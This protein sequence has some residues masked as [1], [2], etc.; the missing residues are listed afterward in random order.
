M[1]NN[2]LS[3]P[4]L[5]GPIAGIVPQLQ[6]A[7]HALL[8]VLEDCER[9]AAGLGSA[10]LWTELGG[11][12]SVGFHLRHISGSIDRLLTYA[13]GNS[14]NDAQKAALTAEKAAGDPPPTSADLLLSL[15]RTIER[16]LEHF[17][18][19]P[20]TSLFDQREVGRAKLPSTVL[21][22]MFHAAEHA[23]RHT[24][25]VVTTAK[26]LQGLRIGASAAK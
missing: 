20:A 1:T 3:E 17:R 12:A 18:A 15:R 22:L 7:A 23:Q 10:H 24:G 9:T 5:R 26:I 11:S 4:W 2:S 13:R 6:P 8:Q 19:T 21:G 25:Q 16:A 14:L